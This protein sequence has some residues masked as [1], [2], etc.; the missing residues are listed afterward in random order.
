VN[1]YEPLIF[2]G[3]GVALIWW[4]LDNQ[5]SPDDVTANLS[6]GQL[7]GS[8]ATGGTLLGAGLIAPVATQSE[9]D[10]FN[11]T[12]NAEQQSEGFWGN[13]WGDFANDLSGG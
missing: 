12:M 10:Q 8:G 4:V 9:V 1:K 5:V 2:V 3:I 7:A 6:V 13:L 11:N